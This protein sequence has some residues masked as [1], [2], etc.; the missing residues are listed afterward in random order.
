MIT[1]T[2][3]LAAAGLF[4][5]GVVAGAVWM[6]NRH[7]SAAA[8][9]GNR[10]GCG[11]H[12][13]VHDPKTGRCYGEHRRPMYD[14]QGRRSGRE[15]VPCACRQFVG[16]DAQVHVQPEIPAAVV[17]MLAKDRPERERDRS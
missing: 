6:N 16:L 15:W 9:A 2:G 13:A 10:C 14:S 4:A 5:L 11:D 3:M 1:I 8:P 17:P 7:R 12:L